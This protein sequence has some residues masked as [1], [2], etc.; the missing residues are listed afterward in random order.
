[1]PFLRYPAFL[2]LKIQLLQPLFGLGRLSAG[3]WPG[4]LTEVFV[5]FVGWGIARFTDL[6]AL[7]GVPPLP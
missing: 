5:V 6:A 3:L 1:M 7:G 4:V 2:T